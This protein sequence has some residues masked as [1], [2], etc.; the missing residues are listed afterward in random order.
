MSAVP[1]VAPRPLRQPA[2]A[3]R[4]HLEVALVSHIRGQERF[5]GLDE[6]ISAISRDSRKAREALGQCGPLSDL[7]RTL[8]FFN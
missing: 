6:L 3:P 5:G 7:D 8:G 1:A 2:E 4:R